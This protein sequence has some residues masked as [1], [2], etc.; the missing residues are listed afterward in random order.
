MMDVRNG[1]VA[2]LGILFERYHRR[3]FNFYVRMTGNRTLSEDLVQ[4]VFFRMLKYRGTYKDK[5]VFT[6]WM[7][8]IARNAR[9]DHSRKH[10]GEAT[11]DGQEE[12]AN[13]EPILEATISQNQEAQLLRDALLKLTREKREVL[14]L[15]RFQDMKY[16]QIAELVGCDPGTVKTRVHRALKDL[17]E[18]FFELSGRKAS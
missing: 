10:K 5:S 15:S 16:E 3:L 2:K 8:Q 12:T 18:I 14:V 6:T 17:R 1:D 13:Q 4:D 7:Y 11:L 9:F